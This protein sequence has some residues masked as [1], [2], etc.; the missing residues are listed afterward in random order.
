M[1]AVEEEFVEIVSNKV[2]DVS[3]LGAVLTCAY[4]FKVKFEQWCAPAVYEFESFAIE[5]MQNPNAFAAKLQRKITEQL[6]PT[7]FSKIIS[8]LPHRDRLID[9][10]ILAQQIRLSIFSGMVS[11]HDENLKAIDS[12]RQKLNAL[13]TQTVKRTKWGDLDESAWRDVLR[14]FAKEKLVGPD[15]EGL[16]AQLPVEV[17]DYLASENQTDMMARF[18]WLC[19]EGNPRSQFQGAQGSTSDESLV[20]GEDYEQLIKQ[21]IE[22]TIEW[23]QVDTTPRTGDH[24]ADLIVHG[25]KVRIAIQAKYYTG[26]VGNAAVQEIYAAKDY[27]DASYAVV[28]T[29]SSYT[30]A[31]RIL[32]GKL[33]VILAHDDDIAEVVANL[34]EQR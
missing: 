20:T 18:V 13:K 7:Q 5:A 19:F 6:P 32:A 9:A 8:N 29:P 24:G 31:A 16:F 25:N 30:P 34:V 33:G 14:E 15:V 22:N 27:Y 10:F 21:R 26:S 3:G 4:V 23:V 11:D 1:T 28:V 17:Y 2:R 12:Y